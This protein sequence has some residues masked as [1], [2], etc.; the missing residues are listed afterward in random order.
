MAKFSNNKVKYSFKIRIVFTILLASAVALAILCLIFLEYQNNSNGRIKNKF[1]EEI[2][3]TQTNG[4]VSNLDGGL[5]D[6]IEVVDSAIGDINNDGEIE[7]VVGFWRYGDFGKK[8][9]Y[10]RTRRNPKKSYHIYVYKYSENTKQ[11]YLIW[12]S[13]TLPHPIYDFEIVKKDGQNVLKVIEG[14]YD[15]YDKYGE[16]KPIKTSYW[17]WNEW[18]FEEL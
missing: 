15:D 16:I 14:S 8:L 5:E 3:A 17:I 4:L 11:D 10:Q 13:S 18:W 9:D 7:R 2:D 6:P 1:N 12:G